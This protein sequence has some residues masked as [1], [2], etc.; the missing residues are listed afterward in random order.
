MAPRSRPLHDSEYAVAVEVLRDL[1][2]EQGVTQED[3]AERLGV[4]QSVISKIERRQRRVD[5]AELRRLCGA[6]K[7]PLS[8]FV[9]RFERAL[10]L[11]V[12]P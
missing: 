4:D 2:A 3:L 8:R 12:R 11:S 6:L 10:R 5:I 7:I 1:R 9:E